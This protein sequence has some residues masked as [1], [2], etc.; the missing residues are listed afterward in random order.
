MLKSNKQL[1][2]LKQLIQYDFS[3]TSEPLSKNLIFRMTPCI[4]EIKF[5]N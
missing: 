2:V 3:W 1:S 4:L 5:D